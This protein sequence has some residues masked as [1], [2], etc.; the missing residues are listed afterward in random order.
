MMF[1]AETAQLGRCD[2]GLV[3]GAALCCF[4]ARRMWMHNASL[5]LKATAPGFRC[6][7][8][9]AD[10]KTNP[11][12]EHQYQLPTEP[13]IKTYLPAIN[14]TRIATTE[15]LHVRVP[16]TFTKFPLGWW[17]PPVQAGEV[18]RRTWGWQHRVRGNQKTMMKRTSRRRSEGWCPTLGPPTPR[19]GPPEMSPPSPRT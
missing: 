8:A 13:N 19:C 1:D 9:W 11:E 14:T 18:G 2:E 7:L 16:S 17:A 12:C 3:S 10:S 4:S 6:S 5:Y 15:Q